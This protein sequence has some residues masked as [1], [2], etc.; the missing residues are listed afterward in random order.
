MANDVINLADSDSLS[1]LLSMESV[2]YDVHGHPG[3]RQN[4]YVAKVPLV[5]HATAAHAQVIN[6]SSDSEDDIGHERIIQASRKRKLPSQAVEDL[7]VKPAAKPRNSSL[8]PEIQVVK[9][10]VDKTPL[11]EV[12]E[13]F[14]DVD[15]VHAR[16]L[17]FGQ[18]N[19]VDVVLSI[20]AEQPSYPKQKIPTAIAAAASAPSITVKRVN[21]DGPKFDYFAPSS[22]EP[23][24]EYKQQAIKQLSFE[25]PYLNVKG[26]Q[27][28]ME[29]NHNHYSIAQRVIINALK[30]KTND[31]PSEEE[32]EKHYHVLKNVLATK[33]L[34]PKQ[35]T[36]LGKNNI[37]R[38]RRSIK[39][40]VITDPIL[41]DE[42]LYVKNQLQQWMH[43]V[44]LRL[45]RVRARKVSQLSGTSMEC[46]CC[47][48]QVAMDEMVACRD[49]G[50]LFCVDCIRSYAE[51][52][53]F[54]SGNLG[55]DKNTKKPALHLLCC[56][57]SG[58]QSPFQDAHLQ[59][60]LPEK[61]LQKYNELQFRAQVDQAGLGQDLCT[62]P[63]C[64]FQVDLPET[65]M[66]LK[67]PVEDCQFESCKKCGKESHI[68]YKCD[69]VAK[70]KR[71]DEG[72][73]KVEEAISQAKIRTCPKC[74]KS[75]IKSDGC[76]KMVCPCGLKLCY[77][78]RQP[79]PK[80]NPY[81]HFCQVP[82][83]NHKTCG[84]CTLYSN[85]EEDDAR[86]MREA[87]IDAAEE[88]R[89]E[90]LTGE[91]ATDVQIN[92]DSILAGP[93]HKAR[94]RRW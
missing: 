43:T 26:L 38:N 20:L 24:D 55:V 21:N 48:D 88:Y 14:P 8:M 56:H 51:S 7:N 6:L 83:C 1:D 27:K 72:R 53:I 93:K 23:S 68:P 16:K 75:F 60:A 66:I 45:Q 32:E 86:A 15:R 77:I 71:Q 13:V 40:V 57:S 76:N 54:S 30:G 2:V 50:H 63:K 82:H 4:P 29:T 3:F 18:Q 58:C 73:L 80:Q 81:S 22:F 90:L 9:T 94:K 62:C 31:K 84:K 35:I 25:F 17:L 10:Q 91:G 41:K 5:V 89:S 92:V 34:M 46:S 36:R 19:K 28:Y 61:T 79:V 64:G 59:K 65:Q 85:N 11:D 52:Q 33:V 39:T 70:L 37:L 87:G 12:C 69:E 67:C 44:D 74:K 42:V 47:F 78:C 49:E